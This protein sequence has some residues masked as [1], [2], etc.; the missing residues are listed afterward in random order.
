MVARSQKM[1]NLAINGFKKA[2]FL[3]EKKA[4]IS[5]KIYQNISNKFCNIIK[6]F[7]IFFKIEKRPRKGQMAKTIYF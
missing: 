1:A 6:C 4:N 5:K 3:N 7:T 2:K